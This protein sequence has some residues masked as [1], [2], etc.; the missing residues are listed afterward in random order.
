M[1]IELCED[2]GFLNDGK[3]TLVVLVV[4]GK[5][6]IPYEATKTIQELYEDVAKLPK[7]K[8]MSLFE[9]IPVVDFNDPEKEVVKPIDF[10]G[11]IEREDIVKCTNLEKD[12]DGNVNPDI[13]IGNE[14]RVSEIHKHNGVMTYLEVYDD[15]HSDKGRIAVL[16]SEVELVRKRVKQ[17][18]RKQILEMTKKCDECEEINAIYLNKETD[19]YEGICIRCGVAITENRPS[20]KNG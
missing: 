7:S 12:L 13:K 8:D 6:R 5:I 18:P 17:P 15:S 19:M 4:D 16:P 10:T 2:N 20:V 3:P 14:Y 1:R 9:N 11:Q